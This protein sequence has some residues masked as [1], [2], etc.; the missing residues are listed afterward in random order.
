[1]SKNDHVATP[2]PSTQLYIQEHELDRLTS[3]LSLAQKASQAGTEA[4]GP[5]TVRAMLDHVKRYSGA[6]A[7]M[8]AQAN[9][10]SHGKSSSI[11]G[12]WTATRSTKLPRGTR[13]T[14]REC[15]KR[16]SQGCTDKAP[17]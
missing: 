9:P 5:L 4:R 7:N 12:T 10:Q 11:A 17:P 13:H 2:W 1:V 14:C 15:Q 3:K 16:L 6:Q 8:A